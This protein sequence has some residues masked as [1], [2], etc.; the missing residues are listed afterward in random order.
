[1]PYDLTPQE[2]D[3]LVRTVVG[4]AGNQDAI[5]KAAVAA[6][7][8]N[9]LSKGT[10]GRTM[11]DVLFAQNQFEPWA[12]SPDKLLSYAPDSPQYRDAAEAVNAALEGFDPTNGATHFYAPKAQAEL[13]RPAPQWAQ[14]KGQRIGDHVFYAPGGSVKRKQTA[15]AEPDIDID[16]LY[17]SFVPGGEKTAP[18]APAAAP[19]ADDLDVEG[20]YSQFKV[21]PDQMPKAV[22]AEQ[23]PVKP[24][25]KPGLL[26][27]VPDDGTFGTAAANKARQ[28]G[29]GV[30]KGVADATNPAAMARGGA[31]AI[32]NDLQALATRRPYQEVA[33]E[34]EARA[35]APPA[36]EPPSWMPSWYP[37]V[38]DALHGLVQRTAP[39]NVL[40]NIPAMQNRL[41]EATG[42]A[43]PES[44]ADRL[45]QAG[46]EAVG[47]SVG[48]GIRGGTS[49][50]A[51]TLAGSLGVVARQAPVVATSGAAG[52]A[53]TEAT[54][55]PL[56]GM[57][58]SVAP[59]AAA[60]I[61][62]G[63]VNALTGRVDPETAVLA[64]A[65]R[66]KYSIPVTADQ[67]SASPAMKFAGSVL[68]RLPFGGAEENIAQT[69]TAF[70]RAVANSFG[71][72]APKVTPKIMAQARDRIGADFDEV[73]SK[74]TIAP[75]RQVLEGMRD[76]LKD[77]HEVLE[78]GQIK[79]LQN[80]S[81]KVYDALV[82]DGRITGE[83]YQA[84]TRRGSPLDRLENSPDPNVK[85]YAG[86]LRD[87]LDDALER[88]APPD[89]LDKLK[90]ARYQ[91]KNMRTVEDL[92]AKAPDGDIS[93]A[94]LQGRVNANNK[95]TYGAAY[96]GGGDLKELADIGQRFLK[97]PPSS[98]TA[99]RTTVGA[100]LAGAGGA[101]TSM[102]AGDATNALLAAGGTAAALGLGRAIGGTM[103]SNWL[104][105][106]TIAKNLGRNVAPGLPNKLLQLGAPALLTNSL[107]PVQQ[108]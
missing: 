52:L 82:N 35:A 67:M 1:M 39:E 33:A 98:G 13:G 69:R 87:V 42:E 6:V 103:R 32:I 17:K 14:G 20:L 45:L 83:Q 5:G 80:Q 49:P 78:P 60:S 88:N 15:Q 28:F 71:E 75:D 79:A 7:A 108:P 51:P 66:T 43:V 10:Y 68:R 41:L 94:L 73:A 31:S 53:A 105:N 54:G 93:P 59:A 30:V 9:R 97:D 91:W 77:A 11:A 92:V 63:G 4:E 40:P 3:A 21:A 19:A 16:G 36:V 107:M 12:R 81:G 101:A 65:A 96:G 29:T 48:P 100:L 57:A 95:G 34:N 62:R 74:T 23:A 102:L 104:A 64:D 86:R 25:G 37:G 84:W 56:A 70:N 38:R 50:I 26:A 89:M 22:A 90:T 106:D 58:A 27:T 2:I 46:G 99:E 8:L 85:H 47:A 44:T 18:S 72:D 61:A 24:T 76:V 55:H